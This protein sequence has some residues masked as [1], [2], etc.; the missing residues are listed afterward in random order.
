MPRWLW[1][2]LFRQ[3]SGLD[4]ELVASIESWYTQGSSI[5]CLSEIDQRIRRASADITNYLISIYRFVSLYFAPLIFS[6]TTP[7]KTTR[8]LAPFTLFYTTGVKLPFYRREISIFWMF[9]LSIKTNRGAEYLRGG[10]SY[11]IFLRYKVSFD[12]WKYRFTISSTQGLRGWFVLIG[13]DEAFITIGQQ[14]NHQIRDWYR[15]YRGYALWRPFNRKQFG[16]IRNAILIQF[17]SMG[18][19]SQTPLKSLKQNCSWNVS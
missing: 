17:I 9:K 12:S 4:M 6:S 7:V 3:L 19:S 14:R 10:L 11:V 13:H 1:A 18:Q 8:L 15:R 2:P 16:K 5:H